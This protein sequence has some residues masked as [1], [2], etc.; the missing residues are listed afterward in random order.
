MTIRSASLADGLLIHELTQKIWTGRVSPEST[1]FRETPE[2]VT[3][4]IAKGGAAILEVGGE[5]IGA[6]RFVFVSPPANGE[7]RWIE[8]K[9]IGI[10]PGRQKAGLGRLILEALEEAGLAAGAEGA[11]LAVRTDQPKLVAYYS[12]SGY[13]LADDVILTTPNPRSPDPVGMRKWFRQ[14]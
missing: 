9:R 6:G 3:A 12:A 5:A 13:A 4:Q 8:I 7:G 14:A 2:T 10:L 11:Q 1:V